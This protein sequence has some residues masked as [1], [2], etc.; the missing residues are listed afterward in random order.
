M[1]V[2]KLDP[3]IL[4]IPDKDEKNFSQK[5]V[6]NGVSNRKPE[7]QGETPLQL[8]RSILNMTMKWASQKSI[9][10]LGDPYIQNEG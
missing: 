7:F 8:K 2:D 6:R 3:I 4:N 1:C 9:S 5:F 10:I